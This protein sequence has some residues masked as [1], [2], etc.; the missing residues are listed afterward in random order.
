MQ[1]TIPHL[2]LAQPAEPPV[3]LPL[4]Q[5]AAIAVDSA[6]LFAYSLDGENLTADGGRAA[7]LL[8]LAE[9]HIIGLV[10]ILRAATS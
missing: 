7:Y 2:R 10:A 8:G 4:S 6:E 1:P 3:C 9:A 5:A